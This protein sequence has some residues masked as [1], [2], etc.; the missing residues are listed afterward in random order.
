M[1][2]IK[3]MLW[4]GIVELLENHKTTKGRLPNDLALAELNSTAP[5]VTHLVLHD[6]YKW[7]Y[8]YYY[9]RLFHSRDGQN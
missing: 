1:H 9:T 6:G 3:N 2:I 5:S 4:V 7:R 8:N